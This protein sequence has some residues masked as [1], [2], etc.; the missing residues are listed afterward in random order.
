M[1]RDD[2]DRYLVPGLLRGLAT[3]K[4][5]TP[6][7]Q[8]LTLSEIARALGITRS[9]AFR[10]VY[11]LAHEG[12]LLHDERSQ[13]YT[14]GPGVMRLTYGYFAT[15]EVVEIAQPELMQ[16]RE[17]TGWSVHLGVLDGTSVMYLVRLAGPRHEASI[18]HIGSRLPARATTLGRV[19]LAGLEQS[20]ILNRY[21]PMTTGA[22]T[23]K[24]AAEILRQAQVDAA[25]Q[26]VSHAGDFEAG[27]VSVAAPVRNMS[28]QVV[29]AINV[30]T[31]ND[32]AAE[33]RMDEVKGALLATAGRVSRLLG[34]EPSR[35]VARDAPG[36]DRSG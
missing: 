30:T 6:A 9:A 18:I 23:P 20:E 10:T 2:H 17:R 16:L 24:V 12:C 15:R 5:F 4:L 3:L 14:L 21:R 22:Q 34:Y 1:S 33:C 13:T 7:T 25:A 26:V 8:S 35:P 29:A 19:L 28:G 32:E 31:P 27:I 36:G 11:T